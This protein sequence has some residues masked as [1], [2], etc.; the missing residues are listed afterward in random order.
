MKLLCLSLIAI[1]FSFLSL[2]TTSASA[3][4]FTNIFAHV[5]EKSDEEVSLL[6]QLMEDS[7]YSA[8]RLMIFPQGSS[9]INRRQSVARQRRSQHR[10][11]HNLKVTQSFSSHDEEI[12]ERLVELQ[13]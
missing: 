5:H 12:I 9:N 6:K 8:K 2:A 4:G 7:H 1:V 13:N 10:Y 3:M 11:T